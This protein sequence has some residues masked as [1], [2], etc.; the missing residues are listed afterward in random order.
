MIDTIG[1]QYPIPVDKDFLSTWGYEREP[2]KRENTLRYMLVVPAQ[3]GH[4]V[5]DRHIPC[6]I[7]R[8]PF[9]PDVITGGND[10]NNVIFLPIGLM[11]RRMPM[12]SLKRKKF[13]PKDLFCLS[14]SPKSKE[15]TLIW[16]N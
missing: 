11:V 4:E 16:I 6:T 10:E 1:V 15:A 5:T 9:F 7:T 12:I 3:N 14:N 8:S 13:R 2:K